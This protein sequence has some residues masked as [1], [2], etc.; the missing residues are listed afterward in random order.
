M[1]GESGR[2]DWKGGRGDNGWIVES[3]KGLEPGKEGE[4]K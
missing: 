4:R 1:D 2:E 3:K